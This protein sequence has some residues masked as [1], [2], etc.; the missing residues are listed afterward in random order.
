[1]DWTNLSF[2]TFKMGGDSWKSTFNCAKPGERS[3]NGRLPVGTFHHL[4][5]P[6]LAKMLLDVHSLQVCVVPYHAT[7]WY[8]MVDTHTLR[9]TL[10]P[11]GLASRASTTDWQSLGTSSHSTD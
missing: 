5:D 7:R 6:A 2:S 3:Q 8:K 1:M 4:P 11:V 10:H 9:D